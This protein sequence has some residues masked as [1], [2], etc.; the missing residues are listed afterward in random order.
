MIAY[1]L[2]NPQI[3][4]KPQSHPPLILLE[5]HSPPCPNSPE[6]TLLK[7]PS[8]VTFT[9]H[10]K[11]IKKSNKIST[12]SF[13]QYCNLLSTPIHYSSHL[14]TMQQKTKLPQAVTN[15]GSRSSPPPK[16]LPENFQ[17]LNLILQQNSLLPHENYLALH[18]CTNFTAHQTILSS[19]PSISNSS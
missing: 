11:K 6:W 1:N 18:T 10:Q 17:Y 19:Q 15:L 16:K 9:H 2:P 7:P 8:P 14:S 12:I 3:E 5:T 13:Q 4:P